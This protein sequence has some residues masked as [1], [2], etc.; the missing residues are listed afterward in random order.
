MQTVNTPLVVPSDP[1]SPVHEDLFSDG[2]PPSP[3]LHKG[4][5]EGGLSVRCE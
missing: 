2:E 4:H 1:V 5:L 3:V